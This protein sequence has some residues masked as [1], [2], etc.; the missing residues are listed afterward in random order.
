M[1]KNVRPDSF[2]FDAAIAT[3]V[4]QGSRGLRG[5][6]LSMFVKRASVDFVPYL[7]QLRPGEVPVHELIVGALEK[8]SFN[9][10]GDAFTAKECRASHD[11][12]Q[13]HAWAFR[14]HKNK[15]KDL[16]YGRIIKS[17]YNEAMDRIELLTAL[18]GT[19]EAARGL[20]PLGRVADLELEKYA[21]GEDPPLS[22]ACVVA[23]DVCSQCH[24][25][26]RSRAEYCDTRPVKL[27]SRTV[28]VC[29]GFGC[30]H[31]LTK[32]A[33]DGATTFVYNPKPDWFDRSLV[34][35]NADRIA[36][37]MGLLKTASMP[38]VGGAACAE[39]LDITHPDDTFA[40][41]GALS[42]QW[43]LAH[44][45]AAR[46]QAFPFGDHTLRTFDGGL[47]VA[48]VET[49]PEA[50]REVVV[51]ALA[52]QGIVLDLPS[53]LRLY[54]SKEAAALIADDVAAQL[55]GIYSHLVDEPEFIAALP[56]N[57]YTPSSSHPP[58]RVRQWAEKL[59]A[60]QQFS[61][62]VISRAAVHAVLNS[63]PPPRLRGLQ[64]QARDQSETKI[65]A[66]YAKYQLAALAENP[67][68]NSLTQSLLI[69]RNALT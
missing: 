18:A 2:R 29:T 46:E 58:L 69:R 9:R 52:D 7:D 4:K 49:F 56:D 6:D 11:T 63:V 51:R 5:H 67:R 59:A 16:R 41:P 17:A 35:R 60:V 15:S 36:L 21:S 8:Y 68:N 12:F 37:G 32:V 43:Q 53:W 1:I 40:R 31:G 42:K 22:M 3:L 62:E 19:E 13:K 61:A 54:A 39:W 27:A 66:E 64:K 50:P 25:K 26:A 10:N 48:A 65:A 47:K 38:V 20:G 30:R 34:E 44:E 24:N 28:P 33:D 55:P 45:L 23:H 14:N 57:P